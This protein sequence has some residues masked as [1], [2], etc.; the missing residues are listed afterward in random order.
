MR[1]FFMKRSFNQYILTLL[2]IVLGSV[3]NK[4]MAQINSDR[5]MIIGRNAL[6]FEDY[7]LAIQYFN[8]VIKAKPYL[9]EPYFYR[10][11]GK[12]YLDDFK[13]AEADCSKAIELNPYYVDAYN[14]R[15]IVRQKQNKST[16]AISDYKKGLEIEPENINLI[17]NI[18][19]SQINSK[20]YSGA[21]ETYSRAIDLSP[22]LISAWLNRAYAKLADKDSLGGLDDFTK[23]ISLNPHIPDG[24]AGRAMVYYQLEEYSKSLNDLDKAIEIR[25][26]E[27]NFY[28]NR[29]II[30]YQ[31]DSLRGTMAD[32]DKVIELEP[33]NAL[34]Y[35]NRGILRAQVGDVN[36]AIDDFSRVLALRSDDY[37]T[38]YNRALLYIETGELNKALYDLDVIAEAY[39]DFAAVYFNRSQV[40]QKLGDNRGAELDYGTAVKLE[41]DRR[42]TS[43]KE[44]KSE[45][46]ASKDQV[47]KDDE[48]TPR[49]KAT[50]K[51]SDTDIS[52]YD[53]IAVL[54]DFGNEEPEE[55][56]TGSLRGRIQNRNIVI[57]MQPSFV[58]TY[59][60]GDT[61]VH[62][63]R[64]FNMELDALNRK[65]HVN[66]VLEIANEEKELSR[67]E[68][69]EVF[70]IIGEI[71]QKLKEIP[72]E[73]ADLLMVRAAYYS[74]VSNLNNAMEDYNA[75]IELQPDN[76]LAWFSRAVVRT[77]MVKMVQSLEDETPTMQKPLKT[78]PTGAAIT[79][80]SSISK[81]KERRILDYDLII[82][83]LEKAIILK[84]DFE[85][86]HYNLGMVYALMRDFNESV[87]H[88]S[89][90]IV[91]NPEFAEAWF[92]RGLI[93]IYLEEEDLGTM[94]LSKAG[95]LGVFDAYNVI[96]RYG[97]KP[98]D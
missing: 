8:H 37:L 17:I 11:T 44:E 77:K 90:A 13:G 24:F 86:A 67:V 48:E 74:A 3:G 79:S 63:L 43:E 16:E 69:A 19:V 82:A 34:A 39:P 7:I 2:L 41:M 81:D 85:F 84:P 78:T 35:S 57:D 97:E 23:A 88:F 27:A 22:N 76:Y 95:E 15:G 73:K 1:I 9:Y 20:N 62:R 47:K 40:K 4:S 93:R 26:D 70:A 32:F 29:G 42:A 83:D 98:E 94:D 58:L 36:R 51:E 75:I 72:A 14:L 53:K 33:R 18:G 52:N 56:T 68:A 66:K 87:K 91:C 50:R 30:R 55:V 61:L 49:K 10:A 71:T 96:K 92:N 6:Y 31:L 64:Y 25:P 59:F 5:M 54:D 65:V 46:L 80:G 60:P 21:I 45:K 12:Y 89:Q 28:L 38:L